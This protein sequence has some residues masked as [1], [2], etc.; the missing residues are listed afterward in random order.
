MV[1]F[2]M[3]YRLGTQV[4]SRCDAD[5]MYVLAA[6]D[7]KKHAALLVNLSGKEQEL[8]VEGVDL[9]R[10]RCSLI[11]QEHLLSWTPHAKSMQNNDVLLIEW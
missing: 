1:A 7:G 11:D 4:E 2:N 5:R 6:S 10:A 9:E 8:T 3:L